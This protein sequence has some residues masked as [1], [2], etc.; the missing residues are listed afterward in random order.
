MDDLDDIE[1]AFGMGGED[2]VRVLRDLPPQVGTHQN[3]KAYNLA[4]HEAAD[5]MKDSKGTCPGEQ[6][7][8]GKQSIWVKTFGC[9][10]NVS[11]SEYMAGQL[12]A[13]GY[14]LVDESADADLWLVN[15]CTVKNPSQ[16]AM[17][18]VLKTGKENGK[19]L[20]VAGCVPQG[21]KGAKDLDGLSVIGVTQIDRVVEAVEET[22]K[23]HTVHMLQKKAL[24]RLDLPKVRRNK[25]VEVLPLSTGC[26]G[27]CTYCKTKHARGELGSY[28]PETLVERVKTAVA[29]GVTEI[30]MSSEDTGAYGRDIGTSLADLL[31][32]ILAVLP[33]DGRCM[34]RLGMT[35]PPFMLEQLGAISAA[36]RHPCV[37][38]YLHVPVQAASDK[39]LDAMNRE[40]TVKQF[41]HVADALLA[42]VPDFQLATD[43]ICGFPGETEE[44]FDQTMELVRKYKFAHLHISQFYPRPGTPAA[45]MKR[46]PTKAVKARSRKLSLLSAEWD[47]YRGMVGSIQRVWISDTAA[48]GHHLVGRTKNYVQ[49]LVP[50]AEG[51]MGTSVQFEITGASRWSVRGVVLGPW[52]IPDSAAAP[53][54]GTSTWP[55]QSYGRQPA[56]E[57]T[58]GSATVGS[59]SNGC[60]ASTCCQVPGAAEGVATSD[61]VTAD[62]SDGGCGSSTCCQTEPVAQRSADSRC[63][64]EA[65]VGQPV[66]ADI[67]GVVG[68]SILHG[69][70]PQPEQEG[71]LQALHQVSSGSWMLRDWLLPMGIVVGLFGML[72]ASLQILSS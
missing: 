4:K 32:R 6:I 45:R 37:F 11:D 60:G 54:P 50:P 69:K 16:D 71:G 17:S 1:D 59:S 31:G 23:G 24:P 55:A 19:A 27:A 20:L 42:S 40:Y 51:L 49:V 10:H 8:P 28:D 62:V 65:A 56:G 47:P 48:D 30:W 58:V 44:D 39:V 67:D 5:A 66:H 64:G 29:D 35:N 2:D 63:S 13:Y 43:I 26:L 25:L 14:Q 57:T 68:S 34:L 22:L 18:T 12:Q 70:T 21:E 53:P 15:T 7:L 33:E 41:H 3:T 46:V 61:S 38:S 36:M 72:L 9:A 52:A